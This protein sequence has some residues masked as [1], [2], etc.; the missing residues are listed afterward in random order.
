MFKMVLAVSFVGACVVASKPPSLK[1]DAQPPLAKLPTGE[2]PKTPPPLGWKQSLATIERELNATT[3]DCG[4]AAYQQCDSEW[5][6][7]ELGTGSET[8]CTAGCAMSS[9]AMY[10]TTRG[11]HYTP[12]SL[13]VWLKDHGGYASGDLI[14]WSTVDSMG[15]SYQVRAQGASARLLLDASVCHNRQQTGSKRCV[16]RNGRTCALT[17]VLL[18]RWVRTGRSM[19]TLLRAP[20]VRSLPHRRHRLRI[21]QTNARSGRAKRKTSA[22]TC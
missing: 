18:D 2:L 6:S 16:G 10:L 22:W 14:I 11:H 4:W 12:G 1:I 15:V 13:N 17:F 20:A 3:G 9:V 8:I 7:N 21:H 19:M 5:G